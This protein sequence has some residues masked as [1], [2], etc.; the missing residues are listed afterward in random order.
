MSDISP[1]ICFFFFFFFFF[2][3]GGGGVESSTSGLRGG[4]WYPE[5]LSAR[6]VVNKLHVLVYHCVTIFINYYSLSSITVAA[7]T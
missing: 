1:L 5:I 2:G 3:G 6:M 4:G 7:V